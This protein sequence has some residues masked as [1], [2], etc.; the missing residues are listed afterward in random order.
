LLRASFVPERPQRELRDLTRY[1]SSLS[2]E[3]ARLVNRIHKVLEDT[4]LKLTAVITDITGKSGRAIVEAMLQGEQDPQ[5]LAELARGRLREKREQLVQAVQGTLSPHHHFLLTAQLRQ[6]DVLDAQLAELDQE[7]AQ[8]LGI[9]S[10]PD[11]PDSSEGQPSTA[12]TQEGPVATELAEPLPS[13]A[14]PAAG[15]TALSCA[16]VIGIL[17][18]VT[19]INERIGAIVMAEIGTVVDRFPS[20]AHICSWAGLC[21]EAKISAGKR[22]SN[23]TGKG[24]RW[25]RQALIEAAKAAAREP[26]NLAFEP[27]TNACASVWGTRKPSRLW[28]IVSWSSS[29]ICS[30]NNNPIGNWDRTMAR[31]KPPKRPSAG[32][33]DG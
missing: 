22:L 26:R 17:D 33:C 28:L 10:G 19:G 6:L 32:P 15:S 16:Q 5:V 2:G 25:L 12:Q 13:P 29:I 9:P 18:E 4:N 21:P 3:R 23:K 1:R 14:V 7:I 27:T 24:N 11:T 31:R 8:R 30:K 20:E